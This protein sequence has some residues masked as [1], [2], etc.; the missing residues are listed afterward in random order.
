MKAKALHA[1]G[2]T[3]ARRYALAG[4]IPTFAEQGVSG[5]DVPAWIG[6]FGPAGM[7]AAAIEEL[8]MHCATALSDKDVATK[9]ERLYC[10]PSYQDPQTFKTFIATQ[11]E[12]MRGLLRAA[13][14]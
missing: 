11:S 2:T 1:I 14:N 4:D 9:I 3:A 5:F 12:A 10:A 6:L 8:S 7:P 13:A